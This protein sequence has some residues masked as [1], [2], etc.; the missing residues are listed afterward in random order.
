M[1]FENWLKKHKR[2]NNPIG[3][4][5]RDFID[6]NCESIES[7]FEKYPPCGEALETYKLARETYI[8]ELANDLHDEL[9]KILGNRNKSEY[10]QTLEDLYDFKDK[11]SNIEI[12][13]IDEE[14][15]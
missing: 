8:L 2:Q 14:I 13:L 11:L 4:L 5:A 15:E 1:S 6:T 7:S 10:D 9:C 3:D 12:Y